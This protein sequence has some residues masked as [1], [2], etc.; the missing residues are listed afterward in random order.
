MPA[1]WLALG[2]AS[3]LALL[4]SIAGSRPRWDR[5]QCSVDVISPRR[6][7]EARLSKSFAA[8]S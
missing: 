3:S 2:E 5:R 4:F 7:A 6:T 1:G 8:S